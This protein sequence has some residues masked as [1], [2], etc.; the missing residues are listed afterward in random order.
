MPNINA[1]LKQVSEVCKT[2]PTP[3]YSTVID[4]IREKSYAIVDK[5]I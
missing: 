4:P 2:L 5:G 3:L 1:L